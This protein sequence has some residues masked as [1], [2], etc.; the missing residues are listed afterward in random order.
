MVAVMVAPSRNGSGG[1]SSVIRT[2]RVRV[3]ES[4]CGA[5]S[6]TWPPARIDGSICSNTLNGVPGLISPLR[7]SGT[8][9]TASRTSGRASVMTVLPADTT[10]PTSASIAITTPSKSA[11]RLA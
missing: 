6:R 10:W 7:S 9:T 2:R 1:L 5:I 11:S 8:S 4:A 3:A